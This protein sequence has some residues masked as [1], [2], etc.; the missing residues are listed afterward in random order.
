VLKFTFGVR[1]CYYAKDEATK[2]ADAKCGR[3]IASGDTAWEEQGG[4]FF[5]EECGVCLRYHRKRQAQRT[6]ERQALIK[7]LGLED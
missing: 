2:C 3:T 6:P 4:T 5:C 1:K 7:Q